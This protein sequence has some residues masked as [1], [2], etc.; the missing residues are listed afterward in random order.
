MI[1]RQLWIV[2]RREI[3]AKGVEVVDDKSWNLV[4]SQGQMGATF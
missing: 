4:E 2:L 3:P 1:A